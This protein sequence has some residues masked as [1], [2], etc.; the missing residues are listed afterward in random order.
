VPTRYGLGGDVVNDPAKADDQG[1][2]SWCDVEKRERGKKERKGRRRRRQ[3]PPGQRRQGPR[4]AR[5]GGGASG[6]PPPREESDARLDEMVLL[7]QPRAKMKRDLA[8][9]ASTLKE[10]CL[11]ASL[12]T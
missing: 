10:A 4:A 12:T 1:S 6:R 11:L 5:A 8:R 9:P 3:R 2:S 7:P